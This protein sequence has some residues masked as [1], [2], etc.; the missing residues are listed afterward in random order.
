MEKYSPFKL[1]AFWNDCIEKPKTMAL[2]SKNPVKYY[3]NK[4]NI[5]PFKTGAKKSKNRTTKAETIGYLSSVEKYFNKLNKKY[6]DL[7]KNQNISKNKNKKIN[8]NSLL[9]SNSLYEKGL[10]KW[11]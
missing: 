2:K 9:K 8:N 7:F 3:R 11:N 1:D 6:P 5:Y 4:N 10:A